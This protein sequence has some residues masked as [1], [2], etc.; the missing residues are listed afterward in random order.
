MGVRHRVREGALACPAL[1][2]VGE[3]HDARHV[4]PLALARG[5][6]RAEVATQVDLVRVRVRVRVGDRVRVG[7]FRVSRVRDRA[8]DRVSRRSGGPG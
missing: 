5:V 7:R 1:R 6:G 3:L 8:G 4:P 2:A